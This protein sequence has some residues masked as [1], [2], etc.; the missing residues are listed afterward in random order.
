[1]D[2]HPSLRALVWTLEELKLDEGD[3]VPQGQSPAGRPQA[4]PAHFP[5]ASLWSLL[6]IQT[7]WGCKSSVPSLCPKGAQGGQTR[8]AT[9]I[10]LL[11][12]GLAVSDPL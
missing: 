5:K 9:M 11:Y 3:R 1:M 2:L 7:C 4:A 8:P 10:L 6:F 12:S